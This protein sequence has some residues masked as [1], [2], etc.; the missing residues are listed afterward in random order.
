VP[1]GV[2][3]WVIQVASLRAPEAARTLQNE[4]REKG[5]PAFVEQADVRGERYYRVRV[6]PEV[7]RARADQLAERLARDTGTDP[8]VQRYP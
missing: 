7:E 2:S 4:L 8:L 5:Y 3:A 1:S 6:G